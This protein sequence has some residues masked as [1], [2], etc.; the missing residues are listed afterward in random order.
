MTTSVRI[1]HIPVEIWS[2]RLP[3]FLSS[4]YVTENTASVHY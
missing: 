1:F 2:F 4:S 3:N